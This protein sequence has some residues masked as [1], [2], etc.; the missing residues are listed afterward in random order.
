[1][2]VERRGQ[3]SPRLAVVD[4]ETTGFSRYDR[5]VEF[6]CVTVVEGTVVDEYETLIQSN[7]D[8]GPVHI[9]GITPEMLQTAP[10]FEAVAGDI[11]S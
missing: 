9:H 7:Q 6:A 8:P 10:Q 4:V 3:K 2:T 1:M 11:A 5:V